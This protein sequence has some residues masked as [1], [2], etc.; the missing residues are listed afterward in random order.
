MFFSLQI[1]QYERSPKT[2]ALLQLLFCSLFRAEPTTQIIWQRIRIR[3]CANTGSDK[4]ILSFVQIFDLCLGKWIRLMTLLHPTH[5]VPIPTLIFSGTRL[6]LRSS[7]TWNPG[8][9][10]N[11][12][13]KVDSLSRTIP[14]PTRLS[15]ESNPCMQSKG[16]T[17]WKYRLP[18]VNE[19]IETH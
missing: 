14:W 18:E 7:R 8:L 2:A 12:V 5:T 6:S 11:S 1:F 3:T 4:Q 17:K 16:H 15:T 9:W 10:R 19:G 13:F